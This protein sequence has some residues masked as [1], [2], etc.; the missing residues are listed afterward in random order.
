MSITSPTL[1]V[2]PVLVAVTVVVLR[3]NFTPV[4]VGLAGVA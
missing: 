2:C 4:M 3:V 1:T